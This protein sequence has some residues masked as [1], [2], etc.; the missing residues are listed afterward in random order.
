MLEPDPK[1]PVELRV[2][3]GR[4]GAM[5]AIN[6]LM[7]AKFCRTSSKILIPV[8]HSKV[9]ES[10]GGDQIRLGIREECRMP[11]QTDKG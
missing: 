1:I 11:G 10:A 6:N 4:W 7:S 2:A 3:S 8:L 9:C 5:E